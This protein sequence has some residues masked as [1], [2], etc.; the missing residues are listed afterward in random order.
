M[1][2]RSPAA[3]APDTRDIWLVSCYYLPKLCLRTPASWISIRLNFFRVGKKGGTAPSPEW[4]KPADKCQCGRIVPRS[5]KR[6]G[7]RRKAMTSWW[8]RNKFSTSSRLRDLN[9]S[10]TNIPSAC[11]IANI[12]FN[13]AMILSYDANLGR[14]EFSERTGPRKGLVAAH[15]GRLSRF[16]QTSHLSSCRPNVF[17]RAFSCKNRTFEHLLDYWDVETLP[18]VGGCVQRHRNRTASVLPWYGAKTRNPSKL[19]RSAWNDK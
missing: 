3:R 16:T 18:G 4:R 15:F 19:L 9:R 1:H 12:A 6:G 11:R 17:N 7:A 8:R 13:D 5:R 14:M 10:A 2:R